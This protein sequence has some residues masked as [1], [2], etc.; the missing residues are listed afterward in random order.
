MANPGRKPKD[1]RVKAVES[2]KSESA[3]TISSESKP[4]TITLPEA[5]EGKPITFKSPEILSCKTWLYHEEHEPKVFEKGSE[6]PEGWTRNRKELSV[7][8]AC[9]PFGKWSSEKK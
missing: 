6:I 1:Q 3:P 9:D 7:V 4:G 5:S 8:W 2:E